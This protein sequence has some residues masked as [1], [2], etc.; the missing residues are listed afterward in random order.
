MDEFFF[1]IIIKNPWFAYGLVAFGTILA[2]IILW[3]A[4]NG[5]EVSLFG[6]NL[7]SNGKLVELEKQNKEILENSKQKS[8]VLHSVSTLAGEVSRILSQPCED[9]EDQRRYVYNYFLSSLLA[10]MSGKK[11][12]NPKVCIFIDAGDGTLKV[13]EAA[14]HSPDGMR[15]LR[16]PITDSAAGH[17][18]RTG[19]IFFSGEIHTPGSR[20]K[21]HPKAQSTY[22]SLICVPIRAGDRVLGVLSVTGD[23]EKSY[24]DDEK[25]Y[26]TAFANVLAPLL[27]LELQ[28]ETTAMKH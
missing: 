5:D 1:Q 16:L 20:F 19:E 9:F 14:A 27:H 11:A 28:Q 13:H 15:K 10:S 4:K 24:N 7:H 3:R 22:H 6:L 25:A 26:L 23:E 17:T 12:N 18:F 2:G 21:T 8:Y